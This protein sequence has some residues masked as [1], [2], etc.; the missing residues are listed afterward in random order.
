VRRTIWKWFWAWNYD[1]EEKWLN[2]MSAIGLQL[3][4][5][6]ICRYE[7]DTGMPD[8]Y[9]Y[10]LEILDNRP[11]SAESL[12]YIKFLEETGVEYIGSVFRFVYFRKKVDDAG[13]DIFSDIDSHIKHLKRLLQLLG[14]IGGVNILIGTINLLGVF[15]HGDPVSIGLLSLINLSLGIMCGYG[16]LRIFLKNRKL[17]KEKLLHE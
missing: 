8:E 16:F 11:N 12:R 13:F 10:R 7:F 6:G 2:D 5:V 9:A 4:S 14:V 17:K 3:R 1:K 15:M